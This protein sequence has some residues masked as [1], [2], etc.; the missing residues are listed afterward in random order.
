MKLI[1][2][3]LAVEKPGEFAD[4]IALDKPMAALNRASLLYIC[5][6]RQ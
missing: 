4:Y 1:R 3:E 2:I 6:N 5:H